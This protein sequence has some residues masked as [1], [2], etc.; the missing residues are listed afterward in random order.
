VFHVP[1]EYILAS[2]Y[3]SVFG[4]S[5]DIRDKIQRLRKETGVNYFVFLLRRD[6][7]EEYAESIVQ[8]LT[9]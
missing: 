3:F 7:F 6:Q 5:S 9:G 2:E 4:S 8:P 1:T